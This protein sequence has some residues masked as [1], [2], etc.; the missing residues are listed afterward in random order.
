MPLCSSMD[1]AGILTREA[2]LWRSVARVLYLEFQDYTQYPSR[3]IY[4][5]EYF[6]IAVPGTPAGDLVHGFVSNLEQ[7]LGTRK[8][9]VNLPGLWESTKPLSE[10]SS[11]DVT[12]N[13]VRTLQFGTEYWLIRDQT[14][15]ALISLDQIQLL[16]DSFISDYAKS[17][18]GLK[19]FLDPSTQ[20]R[21][22][23]GRSQPA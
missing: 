1:T 12:F 14:Y 18:D 5:E 17:H 4:P 20:V 8:D 21:W 11:F 2:Q 3:I 16:G 10:L 19:P 6:S 23:W 22:D 9:V 13:K 7:F 15:S